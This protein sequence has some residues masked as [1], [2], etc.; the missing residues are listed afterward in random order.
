MRLEPKH[1][2]A[3]FPRRTRRATAL[4]AL[5]TYAL[6]DLRSRPLRLAFLLLPVALCA[7][8]YWQCGA[9][10]ERLVRS[11]LDALAHEELDRIA[12]APADA[13]DAGA[14]FDERRLAAL[15]ALPGVRSAGPRVE[16]EV[17]ASLTGART[18][19]LVPIEGDLR[20]QPA[21]AELL[22][23][24]RSASSLLHGERGA[25]LSA[26]LLRW[27][28]GTLSAL[29]P[30][31]PA[32]TLRLERTR[33]DGELEEHRLTLPIVGIASR[34]GHAERVDVPLDLARALDRW[35][36]GGPA[37]A[38]TTPP[39]SARATLF[40]DSLDAGR[41]LLPLL[42]AEEN[43]RASHELAAYHDL[44]ALQ[45]TLSF[46]IALLVG[47]IA[48]AAFA[49]LL[50]NCAQ[51]IQ[52]RRHEIAL[53]QLHAIPART[54]AASYLVQG[55]VVG[56]LAFALA[57]LAQLLAATPL[58]ELLALTISGAKENLADGPL[59]GSLALARAVFLLCIGG[60]GLGMLLP[61]LWELGRG[62]SVRGL[63]GR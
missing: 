34:L 49:N 6:A 15:R 30:E 18:E 46:L 28:G 21:S 52:A 54:L 16:L 59:L 24:G 14:R 1:R 4:L 40:L 45:R 7:S 9:L 61:A 35:C 27:L 36:T 44:Q 63:E 56:F 10:A 39:P 47:A 17:E 48:L 62:V 57:A 22:A 37:E 13:S 32:L 23:W 60:A 20:P 43:L 3:S 31:P 58:R 50:G 51:T 33:E 26:T 12:L 41:S 53:L 29:G 38:P 8:L 55:L 19:R 42:E 2:L 25:V 5:A 11:E